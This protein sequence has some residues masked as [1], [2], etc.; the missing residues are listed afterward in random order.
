MPNAAQDRRPYESATR[1]AQATATRERILSSARTLFLAHGYAGTSVAAI[2]EGADVSAP[3][4]FATFQSKANLLKVATETALVG[5]AEPVPLA[6]RPEMQHVHA[7]E[8]AEEV[9]HRLAGLIAERA[10][11]VCPIAS[12]VYAAAD[13]DDRIAEV[14]RTLD[15]H[16]LKGATALA[17][18]VLSKLGDTATERVTEVRDSIWTLNSP[19]LYRL[20]VVDR[21]WSV[22]QYG[23]WIERA[24][25]ALAR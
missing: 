15:E 18:T 23:R 1:R 25:L 19:L 20:L 7:G 22:A 14:A 9:L 24:L 5:D 6:E 11:D 10:P 12:V 4:V 16:R 8:T 17:R 21:G 2:A 3:T 13:H